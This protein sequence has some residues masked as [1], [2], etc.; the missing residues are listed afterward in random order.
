MTGGF[1]KSYMPDYKNS[2]IYTIKHKTDT[3]LVYVGS[4]V[5]SLRDRMYYHK[6]KAKSYPDR[7]F[8]SKVENWDDW[9]IELYEN[10][11]CESKIELEKR[12]GEVIKEIG[13]LN[14]V[15]PGIGRQETCQRYYLKNK[16]KVD[17][18]NT[19]YRLKMCEIIECPCGSSYKQSSVWKHRKS[20]RHLNFEMTKLNISPSILDTNH[21]GFIN[22]TTNT[23]E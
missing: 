9:V 2:K 18:Y 19:E 8:Y 3:S 17:K 22:G 12:E 5:Q 23:S 20:Q 1:I 11:P 21:Y 4:T 16:E 14:K 15:V 7:S 6:G 10:Y 13:T